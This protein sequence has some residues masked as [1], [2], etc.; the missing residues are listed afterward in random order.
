MQPYSLNFRDVYHGST[1]HQ[2]VFIRI[3]PERDILE[4]AMK[5]RK[6][7]SGDIGAA[8]M[9]HVSL[10]YADLEEPRRCEKRVHRNVS[11]SSLIAMKMDY[12]TV[13]SAGRLRIA[14]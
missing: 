6:A 10:L 8:H 2:C 9:P 7:Y 3:N 11:I 4:A 14:K 13:A 1:F 5:T 12:F